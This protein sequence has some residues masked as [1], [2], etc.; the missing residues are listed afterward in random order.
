MTDLLKRVLAA[1]GGL[2]RWCRFENVGA[3]IVSGGELWDIKG[4]KT[5]ATRRRST[6]AT[7]RQWASIAPYGDPDWR[8][9]FAPAR[10]VIKKG[11]DTVVAERDDP[12][13]AFAGH[14]L[15]TPWDPLHRAY[16][17]G[18]AQWTYLNSPFLLAMPGFEVAE[19]E[20][21][22][23]DG[24]TWRVLRAKFPDNFA[25]HSSIQ[26]FYFGADYLLRRHDYQVDVVGGLP[27]A[28]YVYDIGEFDGFRFPTK[29]RAYLRGPDRKP[30]RD[31]T[32]VWIDL[33]DFRLS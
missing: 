10:V 30:D 33:S 21:W 18:Y 4:L 8:M 27:A 31:R 26:H 15:E 3:T 14:T 25:R 29:R 17:G 23:E 24:E 1:H 19:A 22:K 6:A 9:T 11:D 28:Q 5:D 13:A 7:R 32:Y 2:E 20:P 16:F 12:L